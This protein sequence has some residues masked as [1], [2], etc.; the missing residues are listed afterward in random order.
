MQPDRHRAVAEQR[1]VELPQRELSARP[2]LVV[3]A[4][5]QQHQLPGGIDDVAGVERAA[6]GLA[7]RARLLEERLLAEERAPPAP[8]TVLAVQPDADDAATEAN[9]GFGQLAET[10]AGVVLAEPLVDHHLLAV[11]RPALDERESSENRIDLRSF[12]STCRRCW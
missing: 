9:E 1:V 10:D 8:P 7:P 5:L 11:V 6:L 3:L 12:E 4:Q 2:R